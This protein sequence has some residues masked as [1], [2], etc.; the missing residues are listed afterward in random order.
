MLALLPYHGELVHADARRERQNMTICRQGPDRSGIAT[1]LAI[2]VAVL[3]NSFVIPVARASEAM[4]CHIGTYRLSGGGIVD[5]APSEGNTLR[6][7]RFYG[8]TGSLIDK[9]GGLWISSNC[10]IWRH[11]GNAACF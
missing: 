7:R 1:I 2:C 9:G 3:C 4:D 11:D 10:W 5:I 6:W 8:I